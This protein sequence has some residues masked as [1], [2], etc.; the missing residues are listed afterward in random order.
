MTR[1]YMTCEKRP[2][3]RETVKLGRMVTSSKREYRNSSDRHP[4]VWWWLVGAHRWTKLKRLNFSLCLLSSWAAN[5]LVRLSRFSHYGPH[6][7]FQLRLDG[8][9]S[10]WHLTRSPSWHSQIFPARLFFPLLLSAQAAA[11]RCYARYKQRENST[12]FASFF[13]VIVVGR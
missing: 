7:I 9:L 1:I 5:R 6:L 11:D 10:P 12:N 13:G 4:C 2:R 3:D 8:D